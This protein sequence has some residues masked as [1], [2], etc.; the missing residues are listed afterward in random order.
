[1]R[2]LLRQTSYIERWIWNWYTKSVNTEV[3]KVR[4]GQE[5][6]FYITDINAVSAKF[7]EPSSVV[8]L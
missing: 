2:T 5:K 1:M 4:G 3:L 6:H 8:L 7:K